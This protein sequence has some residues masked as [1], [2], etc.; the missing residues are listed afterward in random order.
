M[1][2]EILDD[3]VRAAKGCEAAAREFEREPIPSMKKRLFEAVNSL[4]SAWSGSWIGYQAD[5]YTANL[6]PAH[7][8][9]VFDSEWGVDDSVSNRTT[10]EWAQFNHETIR[11]EILKRAGGIDLDLFTRIA[12]LTKEAFDKSK[13]DLLPTFDALL[14]S[15]KDKTLEDLRADL[16][17]LES[18]FSSSHYV[19]LMRPK[20]F[21]SRDSLAVQQG[22]RLPA[23]ISFQAWLGAQLSY[24]QQATALAKIARHAA[25]YLERKNTMRGKT[26][27]KTE[28]KIFIGHGRSPAWKDLKDFLGDRLHLEYEEYNREPTPGLS[29]KERLLEML[30]AACFAF[31][32]MTAEDE[33]G[34][35][36]MHAR[37]NV[38]HEAGLFQGRYGF[39]QAII[40]LEEDCEEFSNVH[41]IGQIRFPKDDIMAKS[42]EIR[43]VLEREGI[44]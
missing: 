25:R 37:A 1:T 11:Q 20:Q 12:T 23:H 15:A 35:G 44:S 16:Q 4:G 18:H 8:G 10:G 38:V 27:A 5:I 13:E 36:K 3:F 24:G 17:K 7:P 29:T 21:M 19:K 6:Q 41:G 31:L 32:V 42:E 43:R 34:D 30:D 33:H 39:E 22:M 40:L 14:S 9:E 26:V 2:D 28:G